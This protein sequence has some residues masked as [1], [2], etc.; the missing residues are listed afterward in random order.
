MILSIQPDRNAKLELIDL[1]EDFREE[2]MEVIARL[3]S[4]QPDSLRQISITYDIN[5]HHLGRIVRGQEANPKVVKLLK[6]LMALRSGGQTFIVPN[7]AAKNLRIAI[8]DG[9][10]GLPVH[11]TFTRSAVNEINASITAPNFPESEIYRLYDFQSV[12]LYLL[13]RFLFCA[14][15][16]MELAVGDQTAHFNH[17][18]HHPV[19]ADPEKYYQEHEGD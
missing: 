12:R 1:R 16:R 10:W 13:T 4:E 2:L 14:G 17:A 3:L 6:A 8:D 7:F 11:N 9:G 18:H 15:W 19:N 5:E